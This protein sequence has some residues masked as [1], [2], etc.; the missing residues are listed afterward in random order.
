M[1]WAKSKIDSDTK[2]LYDVLSRLNLFEIVKSKDEQE[3]RYGM[4][5]YFC[6]NMTPKQFQ[7]NIKAIKTDRFRYNSSEVSKK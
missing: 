3:R 7:Q 6:N 1:F 5:S 4:M 2:N